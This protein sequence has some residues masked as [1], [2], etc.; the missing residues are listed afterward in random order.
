MRFAKAVVLIA[1]CGTFAAAEPATIRAA[2]SPPESVPSTQSFQAHSSGA[3]ACNPLETIVVD[4]FKPVVT[5]V[6]TEIEIA[7]HVDDELIGT[8][9]LQLAEVPSSPVRLEILRF[10]PQVRQQL[11]TRAD[12]GAVVD[13]RSLSLTPQTVRLTPVPELSIASDSPGV[14]IV[15]STWRAGSALKK[16]SRWEPAAR[17]TT[18]GLTRLSAASAAFNISRKT[19]YDVYDLVDRT[20]TYRVWEDCHGDRTTEL[21]STVDSAVYRCHIYTGQ[22]CATSPGNPPFCIRF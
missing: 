22:V 11:I 9:T 2:S 13:A 8:E 16:V 6:A 14:R 21:V 12:D 10:E 3:N 18:T 7:I 5:S 17:P 4:R 15:R 19:F 20:E 1:G